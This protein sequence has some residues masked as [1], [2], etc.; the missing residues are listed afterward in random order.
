MF[1][2][3]HIEY[4]F[5]L[6][7]IALLYLFYFSS[8]RRKKKAALKI[9]D[10]H[11]V[12]QL[13][14]NYS[15]QRFSIKF[16]LISIAFATAVFALANL[17]SVTGTEKITRNGIDVMIALDVSKSMLAQ[18]VKPTRLDRAKQI[19]NKL[20]DKLD[21]DRVGLV[22][23]AG[24]AYLQ[25][26]LT[27]DHASAKMFIGSVT[28]DALPTQGTVIADAL[29]MCA[30]SF[31]TKEKKYKSVIL[32]SDGEDH[33]DNANK[34]ASQ[35][36][37]EGIAINTIGIGSPQG[38]I[39]TDPLTN[40]VKKDEDGNT[41]VTKLNE[42]ALIA[43]AEKGK[44]LYQLYNNTDDVVA[45]LKA[46]LNSMDQRVFTEN[47]SANYKNYF[48][49]FLILTLLLLIAEILISERKK[50]VRNTTVYLNKTILLI[51]TIIAPVM[52][53]A[54][55]DNSLIK[56]GNEAYGKNEF[57][58]AI[59]NYKAAAGKNPRN[60][61]AQ[62]NLGNA[63]YKSKKTTD[64]IQ[65][66][67]NFLQYTANPLDKA[68]AYYNKGVA[69]QNNN[70]LPEC[71]DAY[72]N[73]LKLSPN[74][75]D[76]RQNLQKALQQQKQQ[77]EKEKQEKEKNEKEKKKSDE[78]KDEKKDKNDT[79]EPNE[80]KLTKQDAEEKL[81]ALQQQEK[82]LQDKLRKVNTSSPNKP[83]KDW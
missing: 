56:K 29:Q 25:M 44:G 73:A 47:S 40:E 67:D 62:Y 17:R 45:K 9:G 61:I 60:D 81:K 71:I 23:F 8:L 12:N 57:N 79:P 3:Q 55:K 34:I 66:Y 52:L 75:D 33:D 53:F 32:I 39:I 11:L 6:A 16:I 18:D 82:A 68:K 48:Q 26:P 35:M 1:T 42:P 37:E 46:Q 54:Q 72:K 28:P 50:T 21:N 80:S 36:A 63:L 58:K 77:Q 14:K 76:T 24:R 70:Q 69:L 41:V 10:E 2:F 65:A 59:E 31:N 13:I 43:L 4:F 49:L 22:I 15:S 5:A 30:A 7:A 38:S 64:A 27:V 74:D 78:D 20:I 83:T 51:I 19:L